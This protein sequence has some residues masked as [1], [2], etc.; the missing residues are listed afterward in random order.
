MCQ[1]TLD[2]FG[3]TH[4]F[5]LRIAQSLSFDNQDNNFLSNLQQTRI[6]FLSFSKSIAQATMY[7]LTLPNATADVAM[8]STKLSWFLA[9]AA[10]DKGF[11]P[12][13]A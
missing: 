6:D 1:I 11:V 3:S 13:I 8:S 12:T 7:L 2:V 10:S 4:W 9:G 5:I